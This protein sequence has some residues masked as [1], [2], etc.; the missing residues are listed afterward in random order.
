MQTTQV[1][2]Y[3]KHFGMSP[4]Q[5]K[6]LRCRNSN[7]FKCIALS[8]CCLELEEAEDAQAAAR[9]CA[10]ALR[11][12]CVWRS[13][14]RDGGGPRVVLAH[15][16]LP[17]A[18]A[19]RESTTAPHPHARAHTHTHTYKLIHAHI[20]THIH[21]HTYTHTHTDGQPPRLL[22]EGRARAPELRCREPPAHVR[23][24]TTSSPTDVVP[25]QASKRPR[26]PRG[27]HH[28]GAELRK[29]VTA[30]HPRAIPLFSSL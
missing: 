24:G 10:G 12:A 25:L 13:A 8:A 28:L 14:A 23:C 11:R 17:R 30:A 26:P 29:R 20:H 3:H 4:F 6:H 18:R 7:I 5:T 27:Y 16:A 15:L 9:T 19:H 21:I 22:Y 1:R 2:K